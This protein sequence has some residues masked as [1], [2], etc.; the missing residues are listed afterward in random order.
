MITKDVFF[1]HAYEDK[2][3]FVYP[4]VK[5]LDNYS[6]SYWLDEVEI[7]W[8]DSIVGRINEGLSNSHYVLVLMTETFLRKNWTV[9]EL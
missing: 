8:G 9:A 3:A 5:A 7:G 6:V 2:G 1:S 4:L